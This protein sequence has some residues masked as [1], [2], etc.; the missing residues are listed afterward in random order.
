MNNTAKS[1]IRWSVAIA[2][3]AGFAIGWFPHKWQG[4]PVSVSDSSVVLATPRSVNPP[5]TDF[6]Q[7]LEERIQL[8]E[9]QLKKAPA[10]HAEV[11][12]ERDQ[13]TKTNSTLDD[14]RLNFG[15]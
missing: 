9:A 8:T 13:F 3:A 5:P 2:L 1:L 7:P 11:F 12:R 4:Q 15:G 6:T 10:N 14:A